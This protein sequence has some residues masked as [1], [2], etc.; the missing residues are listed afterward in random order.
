ML[1]LRTAAWFNNTLIGKEENLLPLLSSYLK[2]QKTT[3]QKDKT[4]ANVII[5]NRSGADLIL[6]NL[7]L[8]TLHRHANLL[9]LKAHEKT[10]LE[11]KTSDLKDTF[12][13]K[14][15]VLNAVLAPNE[16]RVVTMPVVVE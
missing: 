6:E 11:V 13:L 15:R 5:E 12:S 10:T 7:S 3:Y 2:L 4:V 8:Y 14:F 16:H 1:N 9:T